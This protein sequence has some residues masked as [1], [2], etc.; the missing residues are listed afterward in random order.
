MTLSWPGRLIFIKDASGGLAV[1]ASS[2]HDV[3]V[4]DRVDVAGFPVPNQ[5]SAN[6]QDSILL[7]LG[8]TEPVKPIDITGKEALQGD[9]DA[10][11]VRLRARLLSSLVQG[12]DQIL[13]PSSDGITYQALLPSALGGKRL[14]SVADASI[15]ELTGI[16]L[17]K[18]TVSFYHLPR[19]FQLLLRRPEDL[20]VIETAPWWTARHALYVVGIVGI[21]GLVVLSWVGVLRRRVHQ[22][23]KTIRKQLDEASMLRA[24]AEAANRAKSAFLANMS[25]EIRTPMSGVLGMNRLP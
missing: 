18:D 4:G 21:A 10:G 13:E 1:S 20:I 11:L 3:H 2:A 12:E 16:V 8:T 6:L 25:H 5:Y 19:T 17:V 14:A 9:Y 22:Q 15:V 23:T 7:Q 24:E